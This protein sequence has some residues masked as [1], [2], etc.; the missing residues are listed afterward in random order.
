[1]NRIENL[2]PESLC[3]GE[4]LKDLAGHLAD[5][6]Q[7]VLEHCRQNAQRCKGAKADVVVTISLGWQNLPKVDEPDLYVTVGVKRS[8]PGIP[9]V[10]RSLLVG[11]DGTVLVDASPIRPAPAEQLRL[12]TEEQMALG[13]G[14]SGDSTAAIQLRPAVGS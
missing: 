14:G 6:G 13:G 9:A 8:L 10:T 2:T 1:M 12:F 5:A 3:G 11:D 7:R 4:F